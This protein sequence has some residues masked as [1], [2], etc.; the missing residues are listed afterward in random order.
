MRSIPLKDVDAVGASSVSGF[1]RGRMG[2]FH[3]LHSRGVLSLLD[4][5]KVPV[6]GARA[7][8]IGRSDIAG[9]PAALILGGRLRNATVTWC[10]RHTRD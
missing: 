4:F 9:K 2:P 8:V 3:S 10:H 5:Y 1:Y 6:D 7:V